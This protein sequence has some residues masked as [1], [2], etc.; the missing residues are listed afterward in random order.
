MQWSASSGKHSNGGPDAVFTS[1]RLELIRADGC[2]ISVSRA[3]LSDTNLNNEFYMKADADRKKL[4][5]TVQVALPIIERATEY[6]ESLVD[7]HAA[8]NILEKVPV[9]GSIFSMIPGYLNAQEQQRLA[10]FQ[11]ARLALEHARDELLAPEGESPTPSLIDLV[12]SR[13]S[14]A[15]EAIARWDTRTTPSLATKIGN[16]ILSPE[17]EDDRFGMRV[18][19][20]LSATRRL[21]AL[22]AEL[23]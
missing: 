1:L 19:W 21:D 5:N 22:V 13:V 17:Q 9:L 10:T 2:G 4:L 23:E 3:R 14:M 11:Y 7:S 12:R 18:T 16:K 15:R 6:S 20:A 8:G